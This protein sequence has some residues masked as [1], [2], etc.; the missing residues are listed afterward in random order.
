MNDISRHK[1]KTVLRHA[2]V[3][4]AEMQAHLALIREQCRMLEQ[5]MKDIR[6]CHQRAQMRAVRH[7]LPIS[8]C[9]LSDDEAESVDNIPTS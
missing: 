2:V 1:L 9:S 5:S 3:E 8:Q 6:A 7:T 4:V